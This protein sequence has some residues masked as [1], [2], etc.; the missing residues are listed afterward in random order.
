MIK[1]ED[2]VIMQCPKC[3]KTQILE[4]EILIHLGNNIKCSKCRLE[5]KILKRREV[6]T[7]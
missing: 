4:K 2:Y 1:K 6:I 5:L 3:N 7:K